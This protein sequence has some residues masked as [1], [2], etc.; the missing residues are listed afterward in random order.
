MLIYSTVTIIILLII[1]NIDK[2]N[3]R[4]WEKEVEGGMPILLPFPR[5]GIY[6]GLYLSLSFLVIVPILDALMR[7]FNNADIVFFF[8]FFPYFLFALYLFWLQVVQIDFFIKNMKIYVKVTR[9]ESKREKMLAYLYIRWDIYDSR[10]DSYKEFIPLVS[11]QECKSKKRLGYGWKDIGRERHYAWKSQ[12]RDVTVRCEKCELNK[13]DKSLSR[14]YTGGEPGRHVKISDLSLLVRKDYA[15]SV[16][17]ADLNLYKYEEMTVAE[18]RELLQS[19]DL[20]WSGSKSI[21]IQRCQNYNGQKSFARWRISSD[22]NSLFRWLG[23]ML[24]LH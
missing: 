5:C 15:K 3:H 6:V 23:V 16:R 19:Y 10:A 17:G 13:F 9:A 1:H 22:L 20:S 7:V 24:V 12:A 18:L 14:G 4:D 11:C 8:F 2:T 21:L